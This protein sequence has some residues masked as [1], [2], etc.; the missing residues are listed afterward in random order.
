[1]FYHTLV[2]FFLFFCVHD[3]DDLLIHAPSYHDNGVL[4]EPIYTPTSPHRLFDLQDSL[5]KLMY[6]LPQVSDFVLLR[7]GS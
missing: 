4:Y 6:F 3:H 1:M 7:N 2:S 5:D